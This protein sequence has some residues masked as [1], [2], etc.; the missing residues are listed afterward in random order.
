MAKVRSKT[1]YRR[2]ET[3]IM[4]LK[5]VHSEAL[6]FRLNADS[7]HSK[8]AKARTDVGPMQ[9]GHTDYVSGYARALYD[10]YWKNIKWQLWLDGKRVT[11]DQIS[12]MADAHEAIG[13]VRS[14]I[15]AKVQGRHEYSTGEAFTEFA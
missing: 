8:R 6:H 7:L 3:A 11:S 1:S 15:W 4:K 13:G 2:A 12:C 5:E 9:S 14:E 10:A